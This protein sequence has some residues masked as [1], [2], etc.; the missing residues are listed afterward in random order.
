[1]ILSPEVL[2]G[3]KDKT[4]WDERITVG[5]IEKI[6]LGYFSYVRDNPCYDCPRNNPDTTRGDIPACTDQQR[7]ECAIR[8]LRMT[9]FGG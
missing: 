2:K 4:D 3:I 7:Q 6:L 8:Q 9:R 5:V 1:M